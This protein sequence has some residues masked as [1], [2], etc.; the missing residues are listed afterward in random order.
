MLPKKFATERDLVTINKQ[1]ENYECFILS[2]FF[3]SNS[4]SPKTK[5]V[6]NEF[7][8]SLCILI[9]NYC[10]AGLLFSVIRDKF[11]ITI[12]LN[13]HSLS[14]NISR[15]TFLRKVC[16]YPEIFLFCLLYFLTMKTISSAF[17]LLR[18]NFAN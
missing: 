13:Y 4:N 6:E 5:F 3:C 17:S 7:R 15:K 16:S 12:Y 18:H 1:E 2:S 9:V 8:L 11:K 10:N 14:P